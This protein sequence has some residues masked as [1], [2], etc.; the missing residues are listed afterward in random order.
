M[1]DISIEGNEIYPLKEFPLKQAPDTF[2][3]V[4]SK[5]APIAI[6]FGTY[7]VKAGTEISKPE[8]R[9]PSLVSK[10]RDRATGYSHAFVGNDLFLSNSF[11]KDA[12]SPFTDMF[13]NNWEYTEILMD[14]I[15]GGL[16]N[17][18]NKNSILI[19]EPLATLQQQRS[20]WYELLFESYNN[21]NEV[22]FGVDSL[23]AYYNLAGDSAFKKN[24]IVIN[25]GNSSSDVI[26][27][28]NGK[29]DFSNSQRLDISG[30]KLKTY[31]SRSLQL[32]Y[33]SN[34]P[35]YQIEDIF[36]KFSYTA[37]DYKQE[38]ND[39]LN[40]VNI[41]KKKDITIQLDYKE[42][43]VVVKTDE[44][45]QI[46]QKKKQQLGM[47]LQEQAKIK[48]EEKL[49]EKQED[50][51]Y[52]TDKLENEWADLPKLDLIRELE[53]AGFEDEQDF[54]KYMKSLVSSIEKAKKV[55]EGDEEEEEEPEEPDTSLIHI[56]DSELSPEQIKQKR[57][58]KLQY[59]GFKARQLN[60][61][62]K[63]KRQQEIEEAV[64]KDIQW[65]E[66]DLKSWL[67]DKHKKLKAYLQSRKDKIQLKKELKDRKSAINQ[68][69]MKNLTS[70][71]DEETNDGA[72]G[73]RGA[74]KRNRLAVTLDNDPNDTFGANDKDW[75]VYNK[76]NDVLDDP[77]KIDEILASEFKEIVKLEQLLLE[78]DL[79][80]SVEHTLNHKLENTWRKSIMHR[81]LRGPN[82]YNDTLK[83]H[84]QLH[85]NIERIKPMETL[86]N[87]YIQGVSQIGITDIC[88]NIIFG[89]R[90][91]ITDREVEI[92][93]NV[94]LTGGVSNTKNL[95]ERV[96]KEFE[97]WLPSGTKVNVHTSETP[98]LD[99]YN[100]M[101]AFSK[102][103]DYKSSIITKKEYLENGSDYF[104][105][106]VLGNAL[107][108]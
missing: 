37:L 89:K 25:C 4:G 68:Q 59:A 13:V 86:F 12:R 38:V 19:N 30:D 42:P 52:Y 33:Q 23:Y 106:H 56:P 97:S 5:K 54:K 35:D 46:E 74:N 87:P 31:L 20:N 14:Y 65:R 36:H 16:T 79:S 49:K 61:A 15:L 55:E 101:L 67:A 6:D 11:Y 83:E 58:Q 50:Y 94:Y 71:V 85:L 100:G 18:D 29:P 63:I 39:M 62:E 43:E 96:V 47:K 70:L 95:K 3:I 107:D 64:A 1:T 45:L 26:S 24:G 75:E 93:Q 104:K 88:R 80:F 78:F 77:V 32:K 108:F 17:E 10:V 28:L 91:R 98:S 103:D 27:I 60:K 44:Q 57:A 41:L 40:N 102:S 99:C 84:N 76:Q 69:K 21:V 8:M 22:T 48:R 53:A 105:P 72:E 2:N 66:Q 81:F 34:F 73:G 82:K 90:S 51:L 92:C 9:F 7:E